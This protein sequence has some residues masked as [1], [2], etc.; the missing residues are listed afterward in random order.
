MTKKLT[1]CRIARRLG[2]QMSLKDA[3]S[4]TKT[5]INTQ[6]MKRLSQFAENQQKAKQEKLAR[7]LRSGYYDNLI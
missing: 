6:T 3:I 1:K 5:D 7:Q 4:K 2:K